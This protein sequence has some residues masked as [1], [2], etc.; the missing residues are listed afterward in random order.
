MGVVC[1]L[2]TATIAEVAALRRPVGD[3]GKAV[4]VEKCRPMPLDSEGDVV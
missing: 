3:A 4:C 1:M 2:V